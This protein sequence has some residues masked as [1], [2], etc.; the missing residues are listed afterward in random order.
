MKNLFVIILFLVGNLFAQPKQGKYKL[1]IK[2]TGIREIS[3]TIEIA[4]YN[5]EKSFPKEGKEYLT[6]SVPVKSKQMNCTFTVP[7]GIYSVAL[8]HDAN[9]N[10][11]CDKNLM[12]IPKEG[13]AFSNNVKPRFKAPKFRECIIDVKKDISTK[14]ELIYY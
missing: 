6:K 1:T 13:F 2:I 11:K 8:Y 10:K 14:I 4:L 5:N 3:G 12:G 7:A 9:G